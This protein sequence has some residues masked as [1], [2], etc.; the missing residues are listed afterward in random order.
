M[1]TNYRR[2]VLDISTFLEEASFALAATAAAAADEEEED[3]DVAFLETF[4]LGFLVDLALKSLSSALSESAR[5]RGC[6]R[7]QSKTGA[8]A[9]QKWCHTTYSILRQT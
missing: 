7:L 1:D 3:D 4:C 8:R 6:K 2:T 5:Y 9:K